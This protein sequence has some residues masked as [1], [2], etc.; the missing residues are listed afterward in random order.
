MTVCK[1]FR[2]E[3]VRGVTPS[4]FCSHSS[5]TLEHTAMDQ[6]FSDDTGEM[7]VYFANFS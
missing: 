5:L 1:R 6:K 2:P 7:Y 3:S 4:H